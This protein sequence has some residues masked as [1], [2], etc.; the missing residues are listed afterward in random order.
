MASVKVLLRVKPNKDGTR[1][2]IIQI[3]KDRRPSIITIESINEKHW[4]PE[5]KRVK[6]SH[7]NSVRLNHLITT[8][9]AEVTDKSLEVQTSNPTASAQA[10]R[11]SVVGKGNGTFKKQGQIYINTL[12]KAGKFNQVSADKPRIERFIEFAGDVSFSDINPTL[13]KRYTAWLKGTREISDRTIVNHLVV[14][15]S[16]FSQAIGNGVADK[17][18]YPFGKGGIKIKFP[19]SSKIGL[20]GEEVKKLEKV[21]LEGVEHHARNLWLF[22][23]Y[24]AGMRISDELRLKWSDIQD[25]RLHYTM[26]KNRKGGSLRL[27]DKSKKI[28]N[29]YRENKP[30]HN[31]V[32]PDLK[33][34]KDLNDGN[35][36]Q[37]RIKTRV[38]DINAALKLA[39]NKCDITKKLT[40]H[41]S[42][43]TFAQLAGDKIA[44]P[45]LQKLYRH[46]SINT[47]LGYQ[48]HFT[49]KETDNALDNVL[50]F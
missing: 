40:M 10:V 14:I 23:F 38:H 12:T 15:R 1:P 28:L 48:S 31:L 4:D 6:K 9:L 39:A 11:K 33:G 35:E 26:G 42:R 47:T 46:T 2:I 41:I 37:K 44:L 34:V 49:N 5:E 19:D 3:I 20:N 25:G 13:L 36:V 17:R 24:N 45:V 7:P 27:A 29:E 21:E 50:D 22:S 30:V 8:R 18:H 16:V 43:H 32:F